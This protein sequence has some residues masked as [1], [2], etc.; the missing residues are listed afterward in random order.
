MFGRLRKQSSAFPVHM[1]VAPIMFRTSFNDDT[2]A[3]FRQI[4]VYVTRGIIVSSLVCGSDLKCSIPHMHM[5]M[6]TSPSDQV[7]PSIPVPID[8]MYHL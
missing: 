3:F 4:M 1:W 7:V 6:H 5:H 8:D 2:R